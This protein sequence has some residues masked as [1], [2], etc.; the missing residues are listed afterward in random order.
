MSVKPLAGTAAA[1]K[2]RLI[3]S[4]AA[5]AVVVAGTT[6]LAATPASAALPN[7]NTYSRLGGGALKALVP[8]YNGNKDCVMGSGNVSPGVWA[9]QRTMVN[10]YSQDIAVDSNFGPGTR[11]ALIR[12]QQRI[13]VSADGVYGP[14][15]RSRMTWSLEAGVPNCESVG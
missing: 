3:G 7:C 6:V 4:I 10:C 8:T 15:T 5:M 14:A 1:R 11:S 2:A 12:V 13:G 9:L